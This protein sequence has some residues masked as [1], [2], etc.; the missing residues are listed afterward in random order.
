MSKIG[1][2]LLVVD[3]SVARSAGETVHPVSS[4]CRRYLIDVMKICH[5]VAVTSEI[6]DE[7]K[8]HQSRFTVK[9]RRQMAARKKPLVKVTPHG[10]GLDLG[11]LAD[12]PR[13]IV[14][15]DLCLLEAALAADKVIVTRDDSLRVALN[16]TEDGARLARRFVWHNPV[17]DNASTL[18]DA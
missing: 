5:R 15:K 10:T 16:G 8:R 12:G 11:A 18:L 9:W 13:N 4:A 7:W 2:L 14:E 3:A 17:R 1:S 6:L